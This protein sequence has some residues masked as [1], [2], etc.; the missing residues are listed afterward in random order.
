MGLARFIF[1]AD[2]L[3][4]DAFHKKRENLQAFHFR[5]WTMSV[6]RNPGPWG[7]LRFVELGKEI[8]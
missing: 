7:L 3:E 2:D 4:F 5:V 1:R 8:S 6:C